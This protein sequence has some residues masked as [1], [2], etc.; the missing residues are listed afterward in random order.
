MALHPCRLS[1]LRRQNLRFRRCNN[2]QGVRRPYR[3]ENRALGRSIAHQFEFF[4]PDGHRLFR[5]TEVSVERLMV[6]RPAGCDKPSESAQASCLDFLPRDVPAVAETKPVNL[7]FGQRMTDERSV[8]TREI[9]GPD[10]LL[11]H[12]QSGCKQVGVSLV[13]ATWLRTK[14]VRRWVAIADP[15]G[16]QLVVPDLVRDREDPHL[17]ERL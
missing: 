4:E 2:G 17:R 7:L 12:E 15:L 10:A 16:V 9:G 14:N 5:H 13:W 3:L 11:G 6:R 1:G 8:K